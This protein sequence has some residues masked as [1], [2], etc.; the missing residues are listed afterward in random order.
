MGDRRGKPNHL[1]YTRILTKDTKLDKVQKK[2]SSL[3]FYDVSTHL[4]H[5]TF[6]SMTKVFT[7][8][9]RE[10]TQRSC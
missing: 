6:L 1:G 10:K 4:P 8:R 2:F 3:M 9:R 5:G 7:E